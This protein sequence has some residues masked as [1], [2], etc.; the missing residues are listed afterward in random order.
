MNVYDDRE[1]AARKLNTVIGESPRQKPRDVYDTG[2]LVHERPDLIS[3]DDAPAI[4]ERT[5]A[6][7]PDGGGSGRV[8][9]EAGLPSAHAHGLRRLRRLSK[10]VSRKKKGSHN[11]RKA[12]ERLWRHEARMVNLRRDALHKLTT[13]I[14]RLAASVG[15]ED[16]SD[17]VRDDRGLRAVAELGVYE[18]RRQLEYKAAEGRHRIDRGGQAVPGVEPVQRLR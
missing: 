14:V 12:L 5:A 16:L 9:L 10:D 8:V 17:V 11:R 13:S 3:K 4:G 15:I 6:A 1:L 18:F 2:W 7:S